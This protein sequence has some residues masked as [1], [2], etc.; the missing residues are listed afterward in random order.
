MDNNPKSTASIAGHP[1]H[2][3]IVPFPIAFFIATLGVDIAYAQT[4]NPLWVTASIW[5]LCA[6]LI[7]AALAA[8]LGLIDVA[9]DRRVR[10]LADVWMHAGGNVTA[11]LIELYNLYS[12]LAQG[13]AA[14]VPTGLILSV[15]VVGL[16]LFTG[17]KGGELVFRYRVGVIDTPDRM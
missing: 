15:I 16:L 6:G 12:R 17:W 1:I 3:M 13:P 4:A 10:A 5:L 2:P 11:V 14:V 8:V 7:M 9:G